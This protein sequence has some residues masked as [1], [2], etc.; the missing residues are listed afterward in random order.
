MQNFSPRTHRRHIHLL[1]NILFKD[2][3]FIIKPYKDKWVTSFLAWPSHNKHV[4]CVH[5][6]VFSACPRV[7]SYTSEPDLLGDTFVVCAKS[8]K[9]VSMA[10]FQMQFTLFPYT[11]PVSKCMGIETGLLGLCACVDFPSLVPQGLSQKKILKKNRI[12]NLKYTLTHIFE[13]GNWNDSKIIT[14]GW[15][16]LDNIVSECSLC[17]L[18]FLSTTVIYS[19]TYLDTHVHVY[20]TSELQ[21]EIVN[22]S[23]LPEQSISP[24]SVSLQVAAWWTNGGVA[25][26]KHLA[27]HC[28]NFIDKT[29]P[30]MLIN[31]SWDP[32]NP[33]KSQE[34]T[35]R[36]W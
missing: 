13:T 12:I 33:S 7:I 6:C 9:R 3:H 22:S 21:L 18:F 14:V 8:W 35:A 19:N 5:N 32:G 27:S 36:I 20:K 34:L 25:L 10:W 23:T 11:L 26:I 15:D 28:V 16:L 24:W 2:P 29:E 1:L 17:H 31:K 4:T 30:V